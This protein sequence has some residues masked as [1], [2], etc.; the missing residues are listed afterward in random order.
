MPISIE[1]DH[2]VIAGRPPLTPGILRTCLDRHLSEDPLT[3]L[4]EEHAERYVSAGFPAH[5]TLLFV[6]LVYAWGGARPPNYVRIYEENCGDEFA[7]LTRQ[8]KCAHEQSLHNNYADAIG[9]LSDIGGVGISFG[10][11]FLRFLCP[12]RAVVLDK[13][14]RERCGYD[15]TSTQ[16]AQ[17]VRDCSLVRDNLDEAGFRCGGGAPWRCCDVEMAIYKYVEV[18]D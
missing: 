4:V 12:D 5:G 11:K 16:Y 14:I 18:R 2:I 10:S 8:L 13:N 6:R 15:E 9:V 1:Q 7:L 17:F 3:K